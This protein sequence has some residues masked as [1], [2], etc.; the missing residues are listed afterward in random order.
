MESLPET[1]EVNTEGTDAIELFED[2][3]DRQDSDLRDIKSHTV[4][5]RCEQDAILH[6]DPITTNIYGGGGGD[7]CWTSMITVN[8]H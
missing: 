6:W 8:Y 4:D 5:V 2:G 7:E 1:S 3:R